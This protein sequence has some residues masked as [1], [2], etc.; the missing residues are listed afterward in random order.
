MFGRF[1]Q[2]NIMPA[3]EQTFL[4][5]ENEKN[6]RTWNYSEYAHCAM[7][8][9]KWNRKI[10]NKRW[11][12]RNVHNKM[13]KRTNDSVQIDCRSR[14]CMAMRKWSHLMFSIVSYGFSM[15]WLKSNSRK[16]KVSW[17]LLNKFLGNL[18]IRLF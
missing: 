13:W 7:Q 5:E 17:I 16:P 12:D 1:I 8:H 18:H 15:I 4:L 14:I 10:Q 6:T 11:K 2:R 9:T 3:N